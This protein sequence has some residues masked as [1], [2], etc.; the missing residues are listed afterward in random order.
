MKEHRQNDYKNEILRFCRG[1]TQFKIDE[2]F[3]RTIKRLIKENLDELA[4]FKA[5]FPAN[6]KAE[7]VNQILDLCEGLVQCE[8]GSESDQDTKVEIARCLAKIS[9]YEAE[10]QKKREEKAY[11]TRIAKLSL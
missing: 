5:T 8:Y 9:K 3:D 2:N 7:L 11:K 10:R 1:L 4:H 6:R